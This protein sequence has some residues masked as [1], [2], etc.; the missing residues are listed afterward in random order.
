MSLV[1]E[2]G[3]RYAKIPVSQDPNFSAITHFPP[4]KNTPKDSPKS[5]VLWCLQKKTA[6]GFP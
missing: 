3:I 5:I 1:G 6:H 4:D 2:S